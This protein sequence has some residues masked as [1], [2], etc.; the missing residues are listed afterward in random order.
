MST[1]FLLI[2]HAINDTVDVRI[3]GRTPGVHL[4]DEGRRQ[5]EELAHRLDRIQ[6]DAIYSSPL[7]R[8]FETAEPIAERHGLGITR[9][10]SLSEID[11]GDWTWKALDELHAD[12]LW[13]QFNTFRSG[14]RIP[15]GETIV[16][17]QARTVC[18]LL[19]LREKH[20]EGTLAIVGHGDPIRA[21]ISFYLG[22]P[23]DFMLRFVIDPASV[24]IIELAEA[25][26]RLL[27]MN[28]TA[29]LPLKKRASDQMLN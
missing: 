22:S 10:D 9:L 25:S 24:S 20:P 26:S 6:L 23:L 14:M 8:A 2:R 3:A 4:N 29:E 21:V 15:G 1:T 7:E 13:H 17:V 19:R 11:F 16:E 28:S 27:L 5:A 12:E 18:E